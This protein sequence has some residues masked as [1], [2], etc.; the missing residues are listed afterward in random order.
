MIY[1]T[2]VLSSL[3]LGKVLMEKQT[4]LISFLLVGNLVI[5]SII[6]C[7]IEDFVMKRKREDI[8]RKQKFIREL[9]DNWRKNGKQE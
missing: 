2:L 7:L 8:L 3:Y 6:M 5:A 9:K 4:I 1:E